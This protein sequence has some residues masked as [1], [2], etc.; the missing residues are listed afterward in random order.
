MGAVW[1]DGLA[2]LVKTATKMPNRPA[3]IGC[4]IG[5]K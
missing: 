1:N 3:G 4:I 2:Q 5:L